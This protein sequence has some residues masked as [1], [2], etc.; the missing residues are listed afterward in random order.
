MVPKS[1]GAEIVVMGQSAQ[2]QPWIKKSAL[3]NQKPWSNLALEGGCCCTGLRQHQSQVSLELCYENWKIWTHD[4][5][6]PFHWMEDM[7][8]KNN[9]PLKWSKDEQ[10]MINLFKS[11]DMFVWNVTLSQRCAKPKDIQHCKV[12]YVA[13]LA[14]CKAN[15]E[16][17]SAHAITWTWWG[18]TRER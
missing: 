9:Q 16:L 1:V 8:E 11:R 12:Q 4:S 13:M 18:Q 7:Q 2:T 10:A 5:S 14:S 15:S 3:E 17:K 6:F